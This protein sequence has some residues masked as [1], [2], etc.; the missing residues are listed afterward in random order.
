LVK[1]LSIAGRMLASRNT[2]PKIIKVALLQDLF[3]EFGAINSKRIWISLL[4]KNIIVNSKT[5][6]VFI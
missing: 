4:L 2:M 5:K 6:V 3:A 1:D